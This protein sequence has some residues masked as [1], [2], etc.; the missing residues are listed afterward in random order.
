MVHIFCGLGCISIAKMIGFL[1]WNWTLD[2]L[3]WLI[4]SKTT[5]C[6]PYGLLSLQALSHENMTLMIKSW[7][8]ILGWDKEI[9]QIPYP[10]S[11]EG[12]GGCGYLI[13]KERG[14]GFNLLRTQESK[15]LLELLILSLR[16]DFHE[17]F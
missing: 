10:V 13:K 17:R 11:I 7:C 5:S 8:S 16:S 4:A 3:L 9:W 14:E 15:Y 2:Y 6:I 1:W 12:R